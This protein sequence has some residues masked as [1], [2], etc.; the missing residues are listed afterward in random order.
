MQVYF[1]KF[2]F[3]NTILA[4]ILYNQRNILGLRHVS[5]EA[6]WSIS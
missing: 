5:D 1:L 3:T 6:I 2:Q 4:N